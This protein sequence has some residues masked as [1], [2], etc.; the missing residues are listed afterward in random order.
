[1]LEVCACSMQPRQSESQSESEGE[2]DRESA[3]NYVPKTLPYQIERTVYLHQTTTAFFVL[4]YVVVVN[5][6]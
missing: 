4:R 1:M 6:L 2:L 5:V 3:S